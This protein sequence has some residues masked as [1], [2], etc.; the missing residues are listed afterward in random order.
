MYSTLTPGQALSDS[1]KRSPLRLGISLSPQATTWDALQETARRVDRLGYNYLWTWDHLLGSL[2]SDDQPVFE[3]GT[4][5][6]ALSQVTKQ[7]RLGALVTANTLRHP[8]L[9]AKMAVTLDHVSDGR[10]ILGLGAG[11]HAAEHATNGIDFGETIG[12]RITWLGES[13]RIVRDLMAGRTV[14]VV[15]RHYRLENASQRPSAVRNQIPLLIGGSGVRKTL[16]IVAQ[17]A[18]MWDAKGEPDELAA[19]DNV[20]RERCRE[21]GRDAATIERSLSCSVVIR[22][23]P[24]EAWKVWEVILANNHASLKDAPDPWIGTP[25]QIARRLD[26]YRTIG[27]S[28]FNASLP[29]PFDD[30]TVER[31]I[32]EVAPLLDDEIVQPSNDGR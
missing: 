21:I 20:L 26:G 15:G 32:G 11:W 19:K 9:L 17:Y 10:A 5:L 16:P 31:L 18:D 24:S 6:A 8:A 22:D 13:A 12:E 3:S 29:A 4:L 25:A 28:T 27:F 14:S 23:D 1:P 2:G 30:E 7:V